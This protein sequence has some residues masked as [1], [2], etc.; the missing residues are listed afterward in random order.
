VFTTLR[1]DNLTSAV[2]SH[3]RGPGE[4]PR[5]SPCR[6][7]NT[8]GVTSSPLAPLD[9]R[10]LAPGVRLRDAHG[11]TNEAARRHSVDS[12]IYYNYSLAQQ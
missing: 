10:V 4:T 2:R 6:V 9:L 1:Y 5:R 3:P 7:G 11:P 8:C 12:Y